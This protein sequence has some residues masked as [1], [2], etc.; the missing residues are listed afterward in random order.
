[1]LINRF[2]AIP[3]LILRLCF[4]F[5]IFIAFS[6]IQNQIP[7]EAWIFYIAKICWTIAYD[8]IYALDDLEIDLEIGIKSSAVLFG[9]KV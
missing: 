1:S 9:N 8:T 7:V 6:A 5:G 3:H 4:N 2:F